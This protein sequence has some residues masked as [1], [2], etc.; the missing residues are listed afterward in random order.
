M[1]RRPECLEQPTDLSMVERLLATVTATPEPATA[2]WRRF[3]GI[4]EHKSLTDRLRRHRRE[5]GAL[6]EDMAADG[7]L[8]RGEGDSDGHPVPVYS[9]VD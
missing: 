9:R 2:I 5:T 7:L 6:L 1:D 3:A 4:P 8:L